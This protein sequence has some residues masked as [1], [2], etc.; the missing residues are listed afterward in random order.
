MNAS[1][2][3][4]SVAS[5]LLRGVQT[6]GVD[7]RLR[8]RMTEHVRGHTDASPPPELAQLRLR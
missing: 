3:H 5:N 8:Q 1:T 7:Q 4:D 2:R 6:G